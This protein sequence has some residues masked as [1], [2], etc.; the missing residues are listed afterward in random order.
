MTIAG[1][2][3]DVIHVGNV[4]ASYVVPNCH[5]YEQQSTRRLTKNFASEG[6]SSVTP[7]DCAGVA[8]L[9]KSSR[10]T[11]HAVTTPGFIWRLPAVLLGLQ[12]LALVILAVV[13]GV[14][15]AT[16]ATD[17]GGRA[18]TEG[19]TVLALAACSGLLAFGFWRERS[20]ARTPALLWNALGVVVG[21]TI[22]TSGAP[23]VGAVVIVVAAVTFAAGLRVPRYELDDA[24]E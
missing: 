16:G 8:A 2:A 10:H 23:L 9:G 13:L 5:R 24:D 22:A 3:A 14:T 18:V 12:T 11:V 20:V 7:A 4:C 15:G 19:V 17:N 21:I 1:L 6:E